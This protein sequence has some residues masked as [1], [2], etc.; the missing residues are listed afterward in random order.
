MS[1][2]APARTFTIIDCEQRSDAW[3]AARLG[4]LTSSRAAD[5]LAQG[6]KKNE[7]ST[8]RR[9]LR[10]QLA[11]ER[12]TG[13]SMER[14]YQSLAMAD[15]AFREADALRLF[16]ARTGR[17]T[18]RAGFLAHIGLHAGAS[19]DA[20]IGDF[21]AVVEV[22]CPTPA[23]HLSYLKTRDIPHDYYSQILHQCWVSGA[24]RAFF[25]SYN[26]DFPGS[27]QLLAE[28]FVIDE[29]HVDEYA[30]A[31]V[32]F[33]GDVILTAEEIREMADKAAC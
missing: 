21:A 25:V 22:K 26:P 24:R 27:L 31:A 28:E 7:E 14:E 5:M 8:S 17:L 13:R 23:I 18:R 1:V 2:A 19:L 11:L 3:K 20:Y 32:G 30:K 16:E 12:V 15:G 4:R 6:R 29:R 33:L 9:S 10:V